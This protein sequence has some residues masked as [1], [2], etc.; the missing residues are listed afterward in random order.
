MS[1]SSGSNALPALNGLY[2]GAIVSA[3]LFGIT[4][5]QA[6]IYVNST[7]TSKDKR[8]LKIFLGV[9]IALDLIHTVAVTELVHVYVV[10]DNFSDDPKLT[11]ELSAT[12]I[13]EGFT[14]LLTTFMVQ[15]FFASR[16]YILRRTHWAVPLFIALTSGGSFVAGILSAVF[17]AASFGTG[18]FKAAFASNGALAALSDASA[19]I[20]LLWSFKSSAINL[21]ANTNSMLQRL[22]QYSVTRGVL[23]TLVQICIVVFIFVDIE[24]LYWLPFH[25]CEG[26]LYVITT[27]AILNNRPNSRERD[28]QMS[29]IKHSTMHFATRPTPDDEEELPG[30]IETGEMSNS[31]SGIAFTPASLLSSRSDL[32]V[33]GDMYKPPSKSRLIA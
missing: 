9:L 17:Q 11:A 20:A 26:K 3:L 31:E 7:S 22:Y 15:I 24:K 1:T 30:Q 5:L 25:F 4:I 28:V 16:V 18:M 12:T 27:F 10:L 33:D 29:S 8:F 23:V 14:M 32:A 19:T 21:S 13:L 6:W 2:Y